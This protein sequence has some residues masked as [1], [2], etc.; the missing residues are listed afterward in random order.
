MNPDKESNMVDGNI[1]EAAETKIMDTT[2]RDGEQTSGGSFVPHAD[3][4]YHQA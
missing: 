4:A 3:S 2:L 1:T